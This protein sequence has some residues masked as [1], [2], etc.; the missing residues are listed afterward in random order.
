MIYPSSLMI[1]TRGIGM[2]ALAKDPTAYAILKVPSFGVVRVPQCTN[3]GFID[4][5][6]LHGVVLLGAS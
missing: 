4:T 5:S 6:F 2:L 3:S 1:V